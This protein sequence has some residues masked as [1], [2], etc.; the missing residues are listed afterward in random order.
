MNVYLYFCAACGAVAAGIILGGTVDYFLE[1]NRF[2]GRHENH[3]EH[4]GSAL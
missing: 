4:G 1:K 3:G 2:H